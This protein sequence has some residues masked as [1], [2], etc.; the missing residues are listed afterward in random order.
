MTIGRLVIVIGK[1]GSGKTTLC[2]SLAGRGFVHVSASDVLRRSLHDCGSAFDRR[3]LAE[4][5]GLIRGTPSLASFHEALVRR[6]DENDVDVVLDGPRFAETIDAVRS[7]A[8]L[9]LLVYLDCSNEVRRERLT[10]SGRGSDWA[11]LERAATERS[12]DE[13]R[14]MADLVLDG[15]RPAGDVARS[16]RDALRISDL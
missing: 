6:I 1:A 8:A 3:S 12:V 2:R 13:M 10:S 4:H 9:S 14:S 7:S 15:A 11:W 16:L 5:G